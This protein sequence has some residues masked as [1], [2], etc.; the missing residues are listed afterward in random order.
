MKKTLELKDLKCRADI[1]K[2]NIKRPSRKEMLD[3]ALEFLC[4]DYNINDE[5]KHKISSKYDK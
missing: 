3:K 2:L 1:Y 5:F 4:K